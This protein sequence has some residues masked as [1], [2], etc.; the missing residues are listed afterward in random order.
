[1]S[2]SAVWPSWARRA[3]GSFGTELCPW[4]ALMPYSCAHLCIPGQ[5]GEDFVE[6]RLIGRRR[7][8]SE[9]GAHAHD[10][11]RHRRTPTTAQ[12]SRKAGK[13]RLPRRGIL[14]RQHTTPTADYTD[15]AR[16]HHHCDHDDRDYGDFGYDKVPVA[17]ALHSA[18]DDD[19]RRKPHFETAVENCRRL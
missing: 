13:G 3:A 4:R 19:I 17:P 9:E 15:S 12:R 7:H 16:A 14:S 18:L 8:F 11:V 6:E 1:M 10:D 2:Q 5:L